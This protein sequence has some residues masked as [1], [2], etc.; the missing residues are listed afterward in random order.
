MSY[1]NHSAFE[2]AAA[3]HLCALSGAAL[4][5]S[6]DAGLP[7]GQVRSEVKVTR[8]RPA[9]SPRAMP[10]HPALRAVSSALVPGGPTHIFVTVFIFALLCAPIL[11]I[12]L[13]AD[14]NAY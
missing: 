9:A 14:L 7:A 6:L 10:G 12:I 8:D 2:T 1:S 3:I 13:F 11:Y 4:P 5:R